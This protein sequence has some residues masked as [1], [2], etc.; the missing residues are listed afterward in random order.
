VRYARGRDDP[1]GF[2][3]DSYDYAAFVQLVL[4]P[5]DAIVPA[6][7]DH[8]ADRAVEA[9]PVPLRSDTILVVDGIFLHRDELAAWWDYSIW[10]DVPFDVSIPRCAA[11][12]DGL[13]SADAEAPANRRYVEGQ[14][15]YLRECEPRRRATVV[16]DNTDLAVPRLVDAATLDA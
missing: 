3:R 5:A 2:Y 8:V 6:V 7:F 4:E 13:G 9:E 1:E 14:R 10:L 16:V 11:R 12:G 15:L